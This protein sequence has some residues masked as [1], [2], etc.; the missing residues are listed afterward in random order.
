[1]QLFFNITQWPFQSMLNHKKWQSFGYDFK[2][3]QFVMIGLSTKLIYDWGFKMKKK[4]TEKIN[5]TWNVR[6][7]LR[8]FQSLDFVFN[9]KPI[10][11]HGNQ[12]KPLVESV[13]PEYNSEFRLYLSPEKLKRDSFNSFI[14]LFF[15]CF[16]I[17]NVNIFAVLAYRENKKKLEWC[18]MKRR[19]KIGCWMTLIIQYN[20]E[21]EI[22][23]HSTQTYNIFYLSYLI[24]TLFQHTHSIQTYH[25]N[26][27]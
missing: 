17:Y 27:Q 6:N 1:M 18:A 7:Q 16:L 9:Y 5:C 22:E 11:C 25:Q 14:F 15:F 4:K 19:K 12:N 8:A 20:V 26:Q 24:I 21:F 10:K 2:L 23:N 3:N 13:T